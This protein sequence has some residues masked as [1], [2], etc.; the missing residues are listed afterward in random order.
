MNFLGIIINPNNDAQNDTEFFVFGSGQ[1]ADA[2]ANPTIGEDFGWNAVWQSAVK[3]VDNGWI[4]EVKIPYRCLRFTDQEDPVWG[5]QFHRHFRRER[6]QYTWNPIDPTKGN[7]GIYHGE[8][9]GLQNI[10]PPVRLNL[11]PFATGIVNDFDG[12]S[13]GIKLILCI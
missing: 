7:I 9:K 4:V 5:I 10:T 13:I 3:I 11:Y 8:L 6:S 12:G 2:L 1:Q